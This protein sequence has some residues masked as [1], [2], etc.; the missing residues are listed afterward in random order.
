MIFGRY[1]VNK[2]R[3][4]KRRNFI[5]KTA[6]TLPL[7]TILPSLGNAQAQ[8]RDFY[9]FRIYEMKSNRG[10]FDSYMSNALI[11]ALN[12]MNV[13]QVGVFA[14]TGKTEPA[15]IYVLITYNSAESFGK[16]ADTL[17]ND[18]TYQKASA[19]YNQVSVEQ[20]IF[21]RYETSLLTAFD[22]LRHLSVP[23][24]GPR[25]FELRT[26]E[27]YNEDAVRRKIKMFNEHELQV[28]NKVKLNP[29]FFGE[30]ISGTN[31]P[32][33]TYLLSFRNMEERDANWKSFSADPDW[34]TISKLPEYANTVSKIH[35]TFLEPL[36]YSQ[37]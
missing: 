14:E 31:Q 10:I 33:L 12:R 21:W 13:K 15:R 27:G 17:R 29:V 18:V 4:M 9:E 6:I 7:A 35:R 8:E 3:V 5:L 36:T 34:Q 32:C 22:G 11:P 26:Y 30:V 1:K 20:A 24:S 25:I 19:A 23:A 37:I 16:T 2:T 28:F